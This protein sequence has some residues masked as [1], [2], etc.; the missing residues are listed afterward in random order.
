MF[1]FWMEKKRMT[2][3]SGSCVLGEIR[4]FST[5][6]ANFYWSCPR[7]MWSTADEVDIFRNKDIEYMTVMNGK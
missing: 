1:N 4:K 5:E 3:T 2:D 7:L 6:R